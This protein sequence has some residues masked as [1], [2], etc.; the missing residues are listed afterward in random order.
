MTT[1]KASKKTSI[2]GTQK[3]HRLSPKSNRRTTKP[4]NRTERQQL[5]S[6]IQRELRHIHNLYIADEKHKATT[7][8]ALKKAKDEFAI[9]MEYLGHKRLKCEGT[10]FGILVK[11]R[12]H[13]TFPDEIVRL[14]HELKAE[15]QIAIDTGK[16]TKDIT[17]YA[18]VFIEK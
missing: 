12:P 4:R 3:S 1:T 14:E 7:L 15:K 5:E 16:T 9:K 10:N 11:E 17:I 8:V 2:A 13:H 18:S 6:G